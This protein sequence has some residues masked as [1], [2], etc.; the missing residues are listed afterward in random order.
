M[1]ITTGHPRRANAGRRLHGKSTHISGCSCTLVLSC[2]P[3][4]HISCSEKV[5]S[6]HGGVREADR[7]LLDGRLNEQ[8]S[9]PEYVSKKHILFNQMAELKGKLEA[10]E[11]NCTNRFELSSGG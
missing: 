6:R 8:I 11:H 2:G 3:D 7:L 5:K 10:F 4:Q 9:E 1:A